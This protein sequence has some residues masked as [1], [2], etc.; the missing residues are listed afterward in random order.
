MQNNQKQFGVNETVFV[1][2]VSCQKKKEPDI[3]SDL[4]YLDLAHVSAGI[5]IR[6][7][8]LLV[9]K[10]YFYAGLT[11]PLMRALQGCLYTITN[12]VRITSAFPISLFFQI[13]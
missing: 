1:Y 11:G 7:L 12:L 5:W 2:S 6:K 4:L 8:Q 10:P 3:F 9:K 13:N